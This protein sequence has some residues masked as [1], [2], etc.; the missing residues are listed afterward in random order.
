MSAGEISDA[1]IGPAAPASHAAAAIPAGAQPRETTAP[2][3]AAAKP[4]GRFVAL[5]GLRGIAALLVVFFHI[6]WPNHFT[7]TNFVR[8]GYL[9]VDL[10]FILS[11]LV[12]YANYGVR[13][14]QFADFVQFLGLRFFR[15][16]PLLIAMLGL[17]VLLESAKMVAQQ[18]FG[19]V[20]GQPP[21]TGADTA[22]TLLAN[23]FLLQGLHVLPRLTW[24]TPSWSISCE[25]LAYVLFSALV[26]TG[27]ARHRLFPPVAAVTAA[28]LY[29]GV[30]YGWGTLDVTYDWGILRCVAGFLL[31][32]VIYRARDDIQSINWQGLAGAGEV[33]LLILLIATLSFASGATLVMS[34]A[35]FVGLVALLQFDHGPIAWILM[36]RPAQFLGRVSYS[37]YMVHL[38]LLICM[39]IIVKR[40]FGVTVA[41]NP[42]TQ[43]P[44]FAIGLWP[45]DL[46]AF[47]AVVCVLATASVTYAV[48]EAPARRFGRMVLGA[49][50]KTDARL[51][52]RRRAPL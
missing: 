4:S 33:V 35:V 32:M 22:D 8:N 36:S 31:G 19:I 25:F 17:F 5:D 38:V 30:A 41:I 44:T 18:K 39:S 52:S 28:T 34:V 9:A 46:L 26:L 13:I 42:A 37:I 23:I 43:S 2:A 45:G 24:N 3:T 51:S 40:L 48:I 21:F 10:F 11:G 47:A 16:Y 6:G 14:N 50:V 27:L 1:V 15:V 20:A 7:P 49:S 29:V 12:I